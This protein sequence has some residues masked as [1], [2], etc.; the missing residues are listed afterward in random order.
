MI[1]AR[2]ANKTIWRKRDVV[3]EHA[4]S[5]SCGFTRPIGV[6]RRHPD[7]SARRFPVSLKSR[8]SRREG[9]VLQRLWWRSPDTMQAAVL[10]SLQQALWSTSAHWGMA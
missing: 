3:K 4:W 7:P 8:A 10:G 2:E 1:P 9:G 5:A 6:P